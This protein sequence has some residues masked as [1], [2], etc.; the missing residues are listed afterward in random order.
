MMIPMRQLL[1]ALLLLVGPAAAHAKEYTAEKFDSR[2]EILQGGSLRVTETIVFRFER[3]T[4]TYVFRMIPT[5]RTD[6]VE[7][8]GAS[9]D[10]RPL[11]PGTGP[12]QVE[13][14]RRNG[15]RVEWHFA[16][17]GP[18]TH[19]FGLTYVARGV[20]FVR[21]D[22]DVI[23]FQALPSEHDYRI[24]S[25]VVELAVPAAL[26]GAPSV[27]T[28]RVG[29]WSETHD[30][31]RVVVRASSIGRNGW[32]EISAALARGSIIDTPPAWQRR[33]IQH[34]EYREPA[35]IAAGI[36]LCVGL[37]L[38]FGIRQG[39]E[40]PPR[41]MPTSRTFAA[42][43]DATPPAIAG[44][45]ASN[46]GVRLQHAMGTLFALASS[47]AVA[48]REQAR[49]V[50]GQRRFEVARGR[51]SRSLL[52]HEEVLID[53]VFSAKGAS[54]GTVPLDKARGHIVRHFSKFREAVTRAMTEAGLLDAGRVQVRARFRILGALLLILAVVT[55]IPCLILVERLGGWPFFVPLAIAIVGI[56]SLI[57]GAALTPLSNDGVGRGAEWRA[58]RKQLR[59][60]P[61]EPAGAG[62]AA[63]SPAD[64]LPL[65]VALGLAAAWSRIFK[66]RGA[67]LPA[68]FRATSAADAHSG[69]VAFVGYGGSGAGAGGGHAGGG[70]AGGGGSGAG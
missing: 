13:I 55:A 64:L 6:G 20:G 40:S 56:A 61:R 53:Q 51:S 47:G 38:L 11:L 52:P 35:L 3:G 1:T 65:A 14:S 32:L 63:A 42:S 16:P 4:F 30:T 34:L 28:R 41:D 69:F 7:F 66:D 5:N 17:T 57:A 2:I 39:Y 25:S 23:A 67:Q 62:W 54:D 68:W 46:G 58:Y 26:A 24:E 45:L 59:E 37:V 8:V 10:D 33:R 36:V 21:D 19:T 12:G 48:I 44:A 22:R 43:P 60:K 49:G 70:A 31:R 18:S 9:M 15:L 50:F 27:H 29:D